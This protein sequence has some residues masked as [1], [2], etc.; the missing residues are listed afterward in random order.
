MEKATTNQVRQV[1]MN[2]L[3]LSREA[4]R[5][6]MENIIHDVMEKHFNK[7]WHEGELTNI[8][9]R[10]IKDQFQSAHH[11]PSRDGNT[12]EKMVLRLAE[13]EVTKFIK[14]NITVT[15]KIK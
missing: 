12:L 6:E 11:Y 3:G 2:E 5:T 9:K 10:I 15:T 4:V 8:V 7:M 13:K 1:L 14:D